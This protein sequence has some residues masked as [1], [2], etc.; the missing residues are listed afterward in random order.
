V[1]HIHQIP[2]RLHHGIDRLVRHRR[3]VDNVRILTA[4]DAGSCLGVIVQLWQ[5]N[6]VGE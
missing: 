2:L 5:L 4:L 6:L 1:H 3:F